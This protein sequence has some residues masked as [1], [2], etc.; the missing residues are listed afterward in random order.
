MSAA[1]APEAVTSQVSLGAPKDS[2]AERGCFALK[3]QADPSSLW[4]IRLEEF[5]AM[6]RFEQRNKLA[7]LG[8]QVILGKRGTQLGLI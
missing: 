3:D 5:L 7:E 2:R 1:T 4:E 8:Y 6:L